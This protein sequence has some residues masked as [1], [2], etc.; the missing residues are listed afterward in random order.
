[1]ASSLIP[2]LFVVGLSPGTEHNGLTRP[3]D[4]GL[5]QELWCIPTPMDGAETNAFVKT[6]QP[7]AMVNDRMDEAMAA[8]SHTTT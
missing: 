7:H 3:L 2:L 4:E 5:T 8:K 6:L 1:M